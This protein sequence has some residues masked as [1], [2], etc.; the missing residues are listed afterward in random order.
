MNYDIFSAAGGVRAHIFFWA[1]GLRWRSWL[2]A[3]WLFVC[4]HSTFGGLHCFDSVWRVWYFRV[5]IYFSALSRARQ[6]RAGYP[7]LFF[8]KVT[9]SLRWLVRHDEKE[10]KC[11]IF[12]SI[13]QNS[14][15]C[16]RSTAAAA[17]SWHLKRAE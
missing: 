6:G 17:V 14:R 12:K 16:V 8:L 9:P 3:S 5:L 7:I 11:Q 15:I 10:G 4:G 2:D 13:L 1:I